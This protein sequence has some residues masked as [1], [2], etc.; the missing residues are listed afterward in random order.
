MAID[1]PLQPPCP[2]PVGVVHD[3]VV[4]LLVLTIKELGRD[5]IPG[6][7]YWPLAARDGAAW[8][9]LKLHPIHLCGWGLVQ[10][11]GRGPAD[12]LGVQ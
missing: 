3:R 9:K 8:R 1:R 4:Y 12:R 7:V 2:G 11:C 5:P 10:V 6:V